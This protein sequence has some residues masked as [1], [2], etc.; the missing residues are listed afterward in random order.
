[1]GTTS[2][3]RG[4]TP[5]ELMAALA[6]LGSLAVAVGVFG[7]DALAQDDRAQ[8]TQARLQKIDARIMDY[9]FAQSPWALPR[10]LGV[11]VDPPGDEPAFLKAE[12]LKDAWGNPIAFTVTH[13]RGYVLR[14]PGPTEQ[15]RE[16]EEIVLE[17]DYR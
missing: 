13:E 2:R 12:D 7:L 1:M 17:A 15:G 11:L 14:S 6:V 5:V 3:R 4:M 9:Y 8:L 16:G 10:D